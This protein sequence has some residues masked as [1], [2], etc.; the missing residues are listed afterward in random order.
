MHWRGHS[1]LMQELA[2]YDDVVV[3]VCAELGGRRDAA[4]EAGIARDRLALDPG[5]GFAKTADHNWT[6]LARLAELSALGHPLVVGASRKAFLGQLLSDADGP[7]SPRA[8]DDATT[9]ISALAALDGAWCVRVHDVRSS[10]DAV[11]VA[12]RWGEELP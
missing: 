1:T 11:E 3:D 8:R 7:R 2:T 6:L 5:L 12:R 10:R 9:A 4:I